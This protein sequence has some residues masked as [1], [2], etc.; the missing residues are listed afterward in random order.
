MTKSY[1]E[2]EIA[3]IT[4]TI[5]FS[6]TLNSMTRHKNSWN[7]IQIILNRERVVDK[8][9]QRT[10]TI[11]TQKRKWLWRHYLQRLPLILTQQ[12]TEY[13]WESIFIFF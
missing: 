2:I 9:S 10:L 4:H 11:S 12:I 3:S 6:I 13:K 1:L 5:I 8:I 7:Q